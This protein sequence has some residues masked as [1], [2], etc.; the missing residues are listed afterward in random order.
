MLVAMETCSK[1]TTC[2]GDGGGILAVKALFVTLNHTKLTKK[3]YTR[4][5]I[6]AK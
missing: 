1:Q 3:C 4:Y 2:R 5:Q 6:I